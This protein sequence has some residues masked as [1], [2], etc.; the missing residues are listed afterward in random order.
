MKRRF[1]IAAAALL[2]ACADSA[3]APEPGLSAREAAALAVFADSTASTALGAIRLGPGYFPEGPASEPARSGVTTLSRIAECPGGGG[4]HLGEELAYWFSAAENSRTLRRTGTK[5]FS[6]CGVRLAGRDFVLATDAGLRVAADFAVNRGDAGVQTTT[7]AGSLEWAR[8]GETGTCVVEL[9]S[10][11]D[12]G[13]R[14]VALTG[15]LCA[16]PISG[17]RSWNV[18]VVR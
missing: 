7:Y 15:T 8:G 11:F 3:T 4:V 1:A 10:V 12:P 13:A 18:E 5:S 17:S 14:R 6:G 9:R 2:G 16:V